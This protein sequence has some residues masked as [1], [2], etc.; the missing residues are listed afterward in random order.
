MHV[1]SLGALRQFVLSVVG[2]G[3]CSMSQH[4]FAQA[5]APDPAFQVQQVDFPNQ[6]CL[7]S[8]GKILVVGNTSIIRLNTD[9]SLDSTFTGSDENLAA[10]SGTL[11][12]AN[13]YIY[14][15]SYQYINNSGPYGNS[16]Q[17]YSE[18]TGKL[19][20]SFSAVTVPGQNVA[21]YLVEPNGQMLV[22]GDSLYRRNADGS[23]D[24]SFA[25]FDSSFASE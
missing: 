11:T 5:G 4:I 1:S 21:G 9:G 7:Q 23:M 25:S 10:N 6:V 12:S 19:D 22:W 20:S 13:G 18:A 17:R 24:T 15:I 14:L 2:L 8:D 3:I 16:I